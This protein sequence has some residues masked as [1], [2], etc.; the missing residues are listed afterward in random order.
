MDLQ[1]KM[2]TTYNINEQNIPKCLSVVSKFEINRFLYMFYENN[3]R[4]Y[5]P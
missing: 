5:I 3:T 2:P 4:F 1:H